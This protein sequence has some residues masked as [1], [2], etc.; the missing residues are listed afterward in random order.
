M[1]QASNASASGVRQPYHTYRNNFGPALNG[2]YEGGPYDE[3][4]EVAIRIE[5][6]ATKE[7]SD[8]RQVLKVTVAGT[9]YTPCPW[10]WLGGDPP[11]Q[12]YPVAF[13][14]P[15]APGQPLYPLPAGRS[16]VIEFV[17]DTREARNLE[18]TMVVEFYRKQVSVPV[19]APPPA[20]PTYMRDISA[21]ARATDTH[22]DVPAASRAFITPVP[23]QTWLTHPRSNGGH[24]GAGGNGISV[25]NNHAYPAFN[26]DEGCMWGTMR[27]SNGNAVV[28]WFPRG[29]DTATLEIPGPG[30]LLLGPNDVN[31]T[32]NAGD[33]SVR[34]E[35]K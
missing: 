35:V 28:Y 26:G 11:P 15:E 7:K 23:G 17:H 21:R 30:R 25:N 14:F 8:P 31:L 12:L 1:D 18:L 33:I 3:D 6:S 34:I 13:S 9:S 24:C 20:V 16:L 22:I 29:G 4:M 5:T 32:D 10:G 27:T 2:K 19:P